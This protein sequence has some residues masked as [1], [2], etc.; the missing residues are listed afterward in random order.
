V[1]VVAHLSLPVGPSTVIIAIGFISEL[2]PLIHCIIKVNCVSVLL[3]GQL[4]FITI[5]F[6][7][8]HQP[9]QSLL[10]IFLLNRAPDVNV[11]NKVVY[12]VEDLLVLWRSALEWL[13]DASFRI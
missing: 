7:P 12:L 1:S 13:L 8:G 6:T 3:L 9:S 2:A 4:K 5:L 11:G 10:L